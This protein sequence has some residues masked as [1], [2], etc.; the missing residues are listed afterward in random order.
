M[1]VV[2][3]GMVFAV[4]AVTALTAADVKFKSTW[5]GPAGEPVSFA[6]KKVVALVITDDDSLRVSSEEALAGELTARGLV[7]TPA[8]RIIP[9]EEVKNAD[10]AKGWFE[11]TSAEGVVALRLVDARIERTYTP[12]MWVSPSY[13]TLWGYYGYGWNSVYIPG[14]VDEDQIVSVETLIFSVP[15]N[16]L[17]WGGVSES[18]NAKNGRQLI[19]GLAKE[20]VKQLGKEGL[21]RPKT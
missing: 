3:F 6:G 14:R 21:A 7:G 1:R 16:R 15:Q 11:R 5:R 13:G 20:T 2:R 17:L 12:D 10:R 19:A 4:L 8:Y 9:K 18:K